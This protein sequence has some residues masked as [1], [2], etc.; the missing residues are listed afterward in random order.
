VVSTAAIAIQYRKTKP[1][2]VFGLARDELEADSSTEYARRS[3]SGSVGAAACGAVFTA[4]LFPDIA[5]EYRRN[6]THGCFRLGREPHVFAWYLRYVG[7]KGGDVMANAVLLTGAP[8]SGKTTLIKRVVAH[9][10]KAAGGFYTEEI[11]EKSERRGFKL[12]TLDGREG[13]L[14]HVNIVSP[15]RVGKYGLD[16][17]VLDGIGIEAVRQAIR[18]KRL[19][20]IDEI[21]PMELRSAAFRQVLVEALDADGVV[22]GTIHQRNVPLTSGIKARPGVSVIEL[23]LGN[24]ESLFEQILRQLEAGHRP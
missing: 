7:K 10:S 12:V 20:V 8:G 4:P 11:R 16:L 3:E 24:R 6:Q 19:I 1:A 21:G 15:L 17:S 23:T 2:Q 22:L 13:I 5:R 18:N 14:A 9:L